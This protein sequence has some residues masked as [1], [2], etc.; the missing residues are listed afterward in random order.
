MSNP[1]EEI[2]K[3]NEL[4]ICMK[5]FA[6]SFGMTCGCEKCCINLLEELEATNPEP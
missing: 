5:D 3:Y 2:K 6:N 1:A 4:G